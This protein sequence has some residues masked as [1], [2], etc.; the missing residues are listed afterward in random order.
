MNW[1]TFATNFVTR[2]FQ[3]SPNLVTAHELLNMNLLLNR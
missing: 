1:A 2:N 3:K